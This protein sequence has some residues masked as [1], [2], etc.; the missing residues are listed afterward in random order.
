MTDVVA[1]TERR[2]GW[3]LTCLQVIEKRLGEGD[4]GDSEQV[5]ERITAQL[6]AA[7]E[8]IKTLEATLDRLERQKGSSLSTP[9]RNRRRPQ[10]RLNGY[11]S[12]SSLGLGQ[13][14]SSQNA[15]FGTSPRPRYQRQNSNLTPDLLSQ[16]QFPSVSNFGSPP[17]SRFPKSLSPSRPRSRSTGEDA[18]G[19]HSFG[20]ES[21]YSGLSWGGGALSQSEISSPGGADDDRLMRKVEEMTALVR[22]LRECAPGTEQEIEGKGKGKEIGRADEDKAWEGLSRMATVFK[23]SP[24]L[25]HHLNMD[26]VVA[27]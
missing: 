19:D 12:S 7:N 23:R 5:K 14:M 3:L 11:P 25:R 4:A 26:V 13:S 27:W 9:S 10:P 8:H 1:K 20:G 22:Q 18:Y 17:T 6:E 15:L 2:G 16:A 21:S 24:G